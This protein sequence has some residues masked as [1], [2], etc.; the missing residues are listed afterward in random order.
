MHNY[1]NKQ[2]TRSPAVTRIT[3]YTG[4]QWPSRSSKVDDF[5]VIWKPI[6]D[7][8][9]VNNSNLDP[10]LHRLSTTARNGLRGHPKSMISI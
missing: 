7:V 9:L 5:H 4:C 2:L 8:L 1:I 10:I 3:D 6:C